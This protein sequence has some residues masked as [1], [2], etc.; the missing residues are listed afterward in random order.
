MSDKTAE[1][2]VPAVGGGPAGLACPANFGWS[3]L[4]A[5]VEPGVREL[6]RSGQLSG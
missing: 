1:T 2:P 5:V 6:A 4:V 3:D